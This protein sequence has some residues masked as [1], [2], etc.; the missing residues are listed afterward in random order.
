MVC[1]KGMGGV[2]REEGDD[3]PFYNAQSNSI[4]QPFQSM[5]HSFPR[6]FIIDRR[7]A[8]TH[9]SY[10][11]SVSRCARPGPCH[12]TGRVVTCSR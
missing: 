1:E 5:K 11:S 9:S 10:G 4:P 2:R 8:S 12:G 3:V 6:F 7:C